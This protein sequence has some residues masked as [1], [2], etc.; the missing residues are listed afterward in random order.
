MGPYSNG[1]LQPLDGGLVVAE[2]VDGGEA[3]VIST[4][5]DN[6]GAY[7]LIL[8]EGMYNLYVT[9]KGCMTKK[10][11]HNSDCKDGPGW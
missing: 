5:S 8:R 6:S 1:I 4:V 10:W 9:G 11:R 7:E 3:S 2:S